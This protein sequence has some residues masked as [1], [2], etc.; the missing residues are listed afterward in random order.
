MVSLDTEVVN[1]LK[2]KVNIA[3][4]ISQYV[5]FKSYKGKEIYNLVYGPFFMGEEKLPFPLNVN[6]S[7]KVFIIVLVVGALVMRLSF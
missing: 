5:A 1:D 4:L 6:A 7:K 3:D 2:S